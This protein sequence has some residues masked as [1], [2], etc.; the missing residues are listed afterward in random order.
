MKELSI[1]EK[2]KAYDEALKV[3]HKY[4]GAHIMFT[5]D[6]KEE[7]FPELK[8]EFENEKMIKSMTRLVKTFYDCNFPTPEGFERK[9]MLAWLEKQKPADKIEPKFHEGDWIITNK[10]H[11]WY[12]SETPETTSYLYRLIN[13][14]GKVEVAEFEIVDK[15]ARL[16]TIQDAKDGDILSYR[17]GQW[18]FIY[19]EKID[20]NTFS[21]YTLYSTIHQDLTINDSGFTL[22]SDAI[23]PATKEQRDILFSKIKESG[24]EWD[25]EKKELKKIEQKSVD[26]VKSKFEVGNTIW[27]KVH[28]GSLGAFHIVGIENSRYIGDDNTTIDISIADKD[29]ELV[30]QKPAWSEGD[31]RI[32]DGLISICDEAQDDI[33]RLSARFSHVEAL[34]KWLTSLKDRVQPQPQWKPSDEQMEAL[35]EVYKGGEEQA[36]L[37]SLYS[38]LKKLRGE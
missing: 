36:A 14:Y 8:E 18:I 35:W 13:Q 10:N 11:I 21:Y 2:A 22:L 20:N 7:M 19:K 38:D 1:E 23:V 28:K 29:Y 4:D 26:N 31:E 17:N 16:W 30:D 3:L 12:V 5:Q 9:D 27:H 37:A 24:Y 33:P 32:I 25:A 34:K 15:K 6:L